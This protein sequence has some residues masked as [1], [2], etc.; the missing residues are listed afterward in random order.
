M[1]LFE[2]I[3]KK[4]GELQKIDG[5]EEVTLDED[6]VPEGYLLISVKV[7]DDRLDEMLEACGYE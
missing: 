5:I 2:Q 7:E 6:C 4:M 1:E 3:Y